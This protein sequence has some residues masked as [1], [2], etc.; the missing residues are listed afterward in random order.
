M[1]MSRWIGWPIAILVV[2]VV[3]HV[4][5][6]HMLPRRIEARVL[7]RIGQPN[8]MHFGRRPDE[9]SRGV[10]RPSPD[11][12]YASCP[13]DL[14]KGPLRL[15]AHVA[16][17]TYWSIAGFDAAT[18]NFFVRDDQQVSGDVIDLIVVRPGMT[19]PP[20]APGQ[21]VVNAPTDE[22]LFLTRILINDERD[23]AGLDAVRH[24][25]SCKTVP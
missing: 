17:T 18:N 9:N 19:P 8:T 7:A 11:L 4:A 20:L 1:H 14:S 23:L 21:T 25:A 12:L 22:G 24:Q 10:V 13:F 6:L 2:A 16:H 5:T 3:V 15:T